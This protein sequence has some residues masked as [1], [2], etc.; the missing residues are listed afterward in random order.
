MNWK[1]ITIGQFQQL[2]TIGKAEYELSIEREIAVISC[3]TGKSIDELESYPKDKLMEVA[4]SLD[5]MKEP[6]S[7]KLVSS[8]K[9]KGRTFKVILECQKLNAQ[10]LILMMKYCPT[11]ETVTANIHYIMAVITNEKK[12]YLRKPL[13]F[14][15]DF[16]GKAELFKG[17]SIET[18]HATCVFFC[19][20]YK[21]WL[22]ATETSLL[23]KA[24][25]LQKILRKQQNEIRRK[26]R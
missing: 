15:E 14:E 7:D 26:P 10:Q 25:E 9:V 12:W 24:K 18:V 1:N 20:V 19:K 6:M 17:M 2:D 23:M 4:H 5:F 16:E 13:P 8:F 21:S 3:V 22:E 11:L